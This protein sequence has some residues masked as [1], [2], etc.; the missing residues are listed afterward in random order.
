MCVILTIL[1]VTALLVIDTKI[2]SLHFMIC[3]DSSYFNYILLVLRMS[4]SAHLFLLGG[5]AVKSWPQIG[6][7]LLPSRQVGQR[8]A[9]QRRQSITSVLGVRR[10]HAH[11]AIARGPSSLASSWASAS[12]AAALSSLSAAASPSVCLRARRTLDNL[13]SRLAR[14][15]SMAAFSSADL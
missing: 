15:R 4:L 10:Q 9:S 6:H 2:N 14:S 1:S 8:T 5:H 12:A 11:C 7:S 3:R 13:S